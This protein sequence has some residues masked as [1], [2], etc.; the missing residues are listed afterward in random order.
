MLF[1]LDEFSEELFKSEKVEKCTGMWGDSVPKKVVRFC[2]E[3]IGGDRN[4]YLCVS[5]CR[6]GAVKIRAENMHVFASWEPK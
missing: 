4:L 5:V 1:F 3:K 2:C 6:Q